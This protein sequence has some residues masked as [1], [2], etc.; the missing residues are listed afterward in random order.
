MALEEL[1]SQLSL[2]M[3]YLLRS[4]IL[5]LESKFYPISTCVGP[6]PYSQHTIFP[7]LLN[8]N[9]IRIRIHNSEKYPQDNGLR[10][11]NI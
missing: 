1:F 4:K 6:D 3:V 5:K 7:K 8:T 11:G 2:W 9:P 10:S